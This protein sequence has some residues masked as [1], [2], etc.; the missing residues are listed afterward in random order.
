MKKYEILRVSNFWS[1][2][3]LREE[4]EGLVNQKSKEGWDIVSVSFGFTMNLHFTLQ[5]QKMK[6]HFDVSLSGASRTSL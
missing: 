3:A 6:R 2:K 5:S 1:T 4:A